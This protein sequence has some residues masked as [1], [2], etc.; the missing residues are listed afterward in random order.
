MKKVLCMAA[1]VFAVVAGSASADSSSQKNWG[2]SSGGG[3]ASQH[4]VDHG[5]LGV[6]AGQAEDAEKGILSGS[7]TNNT[8][9][10]SSC[11]NCNEISIIGDGN[12]VSTDQNNTGNVGAQQG[13]GKGGIKQGMM[14]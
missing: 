14:K 1:V 12:D 9:Y 10:N 7:M 5:N 3:N 2:T 4:I 13:I 6:I 11:A 8:Y